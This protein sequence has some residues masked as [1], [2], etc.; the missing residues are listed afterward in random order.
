MRDEL[1][2]STKN[3][4]PL[5]TFYDKDIKFISST[6]HP[7]REREENVQYTAKNELKI[8]GRYATDIFSYEQ[9]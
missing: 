9:S 8:L 6:V 2:V 4:F 7:T 3:G 1:S 5:I